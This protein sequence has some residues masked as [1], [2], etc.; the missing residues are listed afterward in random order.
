MGEVYK[1]RDTRL[2]RTVAVKVLPAHRSSDEYRRQRFEREARTISQLSHPHICALY[3]IGRHDGTDF[4]VMEYIEGETLTQRLAKGAL[5]SE[6][7]LRYGIEIA[8]ALDRA[9]RQGI[10]HRD[11]KPGNIMLTKSGVKLLDF[12]LA[13]FTVRPTASA[14]SVATET[15]R[16][17][18][19][20]GQILGTVQYMSPEQLEGREADARSDLFA[21]GA[22]LYE[23]V[24]GRKAFTGK[25]QASLMAA[26]LQ[27]DPQPI[28]S[29]SPL[30][31]AAL[32]RVVRTCLAKDP[33]ERWQTGH[34]VM[35][36][37]RWIAEGG[38]QAGVPAPVAARR[39]QRERLAWGIAGALLLACALLGAAYLRFRPQPQTPMRLSLLPPD[40]TT[41]SFIGESADEDT[42]GPPAISSDGKRLVFGAGRADDA[43]RLHVRSLDSFEARPLEGTEDAWFPFWSPDG[44]WIGFFQG[45]KL[46]KVRTAG[47]PAEVIAEAPNA[48]GGSWGLGGTIVFAPKGGGAIYRVSDRGGTPAPVTFPNAPENALSHRFPSFLPDGRHFLYLAMRAGGSD[49]IREEQLG[50]FVGSTESRETLRL[51]P[52]RSN[53]VYVPPGFLLFRREDTLMAVPFDAGALKPKGAAVPVA[54]PIQF[55]A[56]RAHGIFSA[57]ATGVLA[58]R[59]S[60]GAPRQRLE[61]FDRSGKAAEMPEVPPAVMGET[62]LSSDARKT[63]VTTLDPQDGHVELWS[64]DL[65]QGARTRLASGTNSADSPVW[66]P[67]NRRVAF[68]DRSSGASAFYVTDAS[69]EGKPELVSES[70]QDRAPLDW[71]SDG[72]WILFLQS[73]AAAGPGLG[74]PELWIWSVAER[75]ASPYLQTESRTADGV[76]SP[77]TRWV[78]YQSNE[79]GQVEVSV[80]PFPGPGER[81]QIS[82]GGGSEP[83]WSRDGREIVYRAAAWKLMAVEVMTQGSLRTGEPRLLF[84][85]PANTVDWDISGDHQ[86]ILAAI[87]VAE[88]QPAG[89]LSIVTNWTAGLPR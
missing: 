63:L 62:R 56:M 58:Y 64:Y 76:F 75:K 86:R 54:T 81:K 35:L 52:D 87:P 34:D 68:A 53:A 17:L 67:D 82:R 8:D 88:K 27:N 2:E 14:T 15:A 3:D 74:K 40:G 89:P 69:G 31:P 49:G 61:W 57:S 33:E 72:R 23:M 29:I 24:T 25:S 66:S 80:R 5:A 10:V 18:T 28:P 46:K 50:I 60:A 19:D 6:Q 1:A 26:I 20:T 16:E 13:K 21:F 71:S 84:S 79:S 32:D 7:Y 38:S 59:R 47:G 85:L 41:F 30:T 39:H 44:D 55:S 36:Q 78:A 65:P 73:V 42:P 77:D 11:L 43:F 51:L 22:V 45:E 48:R 37:L 4:L 70:T 83:R 12:G 9:H